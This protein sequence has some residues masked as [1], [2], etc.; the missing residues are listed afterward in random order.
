MQTDM[1]IAILNRLER[2]E[3]KLD[4]L[5]RLP[6]VQDYYGVAEFAERADREEFTVR[7]WCRLG[8]INAEKR[9]CGRGTSHEWKISHAELLRYLSEGLLPDPRRNRATDAGSVSNKARQLPTK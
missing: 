1:D 4:S 6:P 7:E 8:R 5:A 9:N 3:A 2:I